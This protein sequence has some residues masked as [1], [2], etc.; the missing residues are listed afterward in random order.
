MLALHVLIMAQVGVFV[1]HAR[2]ARVSHGFASVL[3]EVAYSELL[4]RG[5]TCSWLTKFM[6]SRRLVTTA[7]SLTLYSA[8][9]SSGW[10]LWLM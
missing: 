1:L 2:H 10:T 6:P 4:E 9:S 8:H 7:A 5:F 3:H